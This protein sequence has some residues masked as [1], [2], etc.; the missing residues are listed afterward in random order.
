MGELPNRFADQRDSPA[1]YRHPVRSLFPG[2]R[3]GVRRPIAAKRLP[4]PR[5]DAGATDANFA[6]ERGAGDCLFKTNISLF[7]KS[8][9]CARGGRDPCT[10]RTSRFLLG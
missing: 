5:R 2:R 3:W 4:C 10:L 6:R 9:E 1:S 7:G 8:C